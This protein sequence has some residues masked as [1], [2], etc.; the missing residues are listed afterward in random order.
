MFQCKSVC[1]FGG[2][3]KRKAQQFRPTFVRHEKLYTIYGTIC[4]VG[5]WRKSFLS[6]P[7]SSAFFA[8]V[9]LILYFTFRFL[10]SFAVALFLSL[11]THIH[12]KTRIHTHTHKKCHKTIW[13]RRVDDTATKSGEKFPH[14]YFVDIL[15]SLCVGWFERKRKKERKW[16]CVFCVELYQ[17]TYILW[18]ISFSNGW[19]IYACCFVIYLKHLR[20]QC[21]IN[22]RKLFNTTF[23]VEWIRTEW[24]C[25]LANFV[26]WLYFTLRSC[27][28][29]FLY[30]S[31]HFFC[32]SHLQ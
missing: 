13:R 25:R 7:S 11:L 15:C 2:K 17:D 24:S 30:F 20:Q 16:E 26:V 32:S 18:E 12:I 21:G 3:A 28:F 1:H 23:N 22:C 19:E 14:N 9:A 8:L 6:L 27:V 31:L 4:I 5:I 10:L 29:V